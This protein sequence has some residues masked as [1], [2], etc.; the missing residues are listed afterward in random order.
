MVGDFIFYL[1]DVPTKNRNY[2]EHMGIE[3]ESHF[4]PPKWTYCFHIITLARAKMA[5]RLLSVNSDS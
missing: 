5:G 3:R 1:R 4:L 2:R